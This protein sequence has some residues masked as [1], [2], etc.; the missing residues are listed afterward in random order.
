MNERVHHLG[1]SLSNGQLWKA[2]KFEF[3]QMMQMLK[4][5]I[6]IDMEKRKKKKFPKYNRKTRRKLHLH[7]HTKNHAL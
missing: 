1:Q 6:H 5:W 4:N 7:N 3:D 2:I